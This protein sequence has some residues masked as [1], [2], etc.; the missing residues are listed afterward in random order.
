MSTATT[1]LLQCRYFVAELKS[2]FSI[3][4][5]VISGFAYTGYTSWAMLFLSFL[6]LSGF[7]YLA[8][9]DLHRTIA[10]LQHKV[11]SEYVTKTT[12]YWPKELFPPLTWQEER[13]ELGQ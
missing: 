2:S 8:Q 10:E 6:L 3:L 13:G 11:A 1:N 7:S 12:E 5:I 9:G 4:N